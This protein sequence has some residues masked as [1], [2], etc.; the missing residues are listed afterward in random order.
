MNA[1]IE[2]KMV[3]EFKQG[4][5]QVVEGEYACSF[6]LK[7]ELS[8][9]EDYLKRVIWDLRIGKQIMTENCNRKL[10]NICE[11]GLQEMESKKIII[12]LDDN[13]KSFTPTIRYLHTR[14]E[15]AEL[16]RQALPKLFG[17][18]TIEYQIDRYIRSTAKNPQTAKAFNSDLRQF[19]KYLHDHNIETVEQLGTLSA[20]R[21]EEFCSAFFSRRARIDSAKTLDRKRSSIRKFLKYQNSVYNRVFT[22]VPY[23]RPFWA[24]K[25]DKKKTTPKLTCREWTSLAAQLRKS[26]NTGLYP[27][28]T[29]IVMIDELRLSDCLSM[30]WID[31]DID[32]KGIHISNHSGES[33]LNRYIV[34]PDKILNAFLSL[35]K[36]KGKKEFVFNISRQSFDKSLN[37]HAQ[38]AGIHKRISFKSL[39]GIRPEPY[40]RQIH[41]DLSAGRHD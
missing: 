32:N 24:E 20:E 31:I 6:K 26:K 5:D 30:R 13:L 27:L 36:K 35:Q 39:R 33:T 25:A 18:D 10:Q 38:K 34:L 37:L 23:I 11:C 8:W 1:Q 9:T 40:G 4:Y 3:S 17:E 7:Q 28:T 16:E 2:D 12:W 29:L 22:Y 21:L 19:L 14:S 15:V 41:P